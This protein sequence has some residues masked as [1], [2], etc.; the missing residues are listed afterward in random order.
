MVFCILSIDFFSASMSFFLSSRSGACSF[1]TASIAINSCSS[2]SSEMSK[3][4]LYSSGI[5]SCHAAAATP[6]PSVFSATPAFSDFGR[7]GSKYSVHLY[8]ISSIFLV[9][10]ASFA[11]VSPTVVDHF[12]TSLRSPDSFATR[13]DFLCLY[14]ASLCSSGLARS[15]SC[16]IMTNVC[17]LSDSFC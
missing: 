13:S 10:P 9:S 8:W 17:L 5:P 14:S 12:S 1:E 15:D 7:Y 16:S 6:A 2:R 4:S 11:S 3:V